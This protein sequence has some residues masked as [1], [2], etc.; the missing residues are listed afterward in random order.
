MKIDD[1]FLPWSVFIADLSSID[2]QIEEEGVRMEIEKIKVGLP[3]QLEILPD[4][5]GQLA[6]GAAAPLYNLETSF[7]PVFHQL[8]L[9]LDVQQLEEEE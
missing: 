8:E 2:G 7:L 1:A 5:E 3:I 9:T 4:E 6:I